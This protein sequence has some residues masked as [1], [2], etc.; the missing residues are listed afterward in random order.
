MT[1]SRAW[2][3]AVGC[4]VVGAGTGFLSGRR[5]ARTAAPADDSATVATFR[6]GRVS[7][8][9][10]RTALEEQGAVARSQPDARRRV[11]RALLQEKLIE[12]DAIAKGYDRAPDVDRE[13][14]RALV[15]AYLR[16]EAVDPAN[17]REITDADLQIWLDAHRSEF[18]QPERVRIAE[19]FL[20]APVSGPERKNRMRET[21]SLL[22]DLREKASRDYYAFAT[23]ARTRSDDLST[24]AFGGDLPMLS[25][26]ELETRL[27]PE[28]AEAAFALRGH[29]TVADRVIETARGFYAIQLRARVE[30]T[31]GDV[32][33]LRNLLRPRV[34]AERRTR[35]ESD[36]YAALEQ[37]ADVQVDD[38]ALAAVDLQSSG[39][40]ASR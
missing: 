26:Q 9:E 10:L 21:E 25:R 22:R 28:V 19:I 7:A 15:A 24:R 23:A 8:A 6:G 3:I 5:V 30:A 1:T 20:A 14:R 2:T 35:A 17:R 13:R 36:L 27:G 12:L 38:A 11:V 34:A 29:D 18:D 37:R 16:G 4:L 31:H 39:S 33:S 40:H 32:A